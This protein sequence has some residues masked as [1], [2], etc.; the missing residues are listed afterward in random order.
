MLCQ[1]WLNFEK[2]VHYL[3]GL[4]AQKLHQQKGWFP[5]LWPPSLK[6]WLTFCSFVLDIKI[7]GRSLPS[8]IKTVTDDLEKIFY[9]P[10]YVH[11][12]TI[13]FPWNVFEQTWISF[14]KQR[15]DI[16]YC[17]NWYCQHHIFLSIYYVTIKCKAFHSMK[18]ELPLSENILRQVLF[19]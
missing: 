9:T 8:L 6:Y 16:K 7:F 13:I 4:L 14:T 5:K 2:D 17:S 19:K 18:V 11:S 12:E 15:V 10:V 3:V 1:D